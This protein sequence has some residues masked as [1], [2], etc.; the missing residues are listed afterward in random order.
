[1]G[2]NKFLLL[3]GTSFNI[4]QTISPLQCRALQK[5]WITLSLLLKFCYI[6][7]TH[8]CRNHGWYTADTVG[9]C[10]NMSSWGEENN[11]NS[12]PVSRKLRHTCKITVIKNRL[13]CL[14]LTV[15]PIS[16]LNGIRVYSFNMR[17]VNLIVIMFILRQKG[18][19]QVSCK[20]VIR[21]QKRRFF[22]VN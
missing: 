16:K 13:S 15:N 22:S 9:L 4:I 12:L 10:L 19:A 21:T 6:D 18:M 7:F 1:M 8:C 17:E 14:L 3:Y 11:D 20:H 5:I 2:V